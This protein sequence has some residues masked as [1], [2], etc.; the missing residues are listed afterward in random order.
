MKAWEW[1][2]H[3]AL[4]LLDDLPSLILSVV[5][6][7]PAIAAAI[8]VTFAKSRAWL[9]DIV[10][11]YRL[12]SLLVVVAVVF[13]AV[14]GW[15]LSKRLRKIAERVSA[16]ERNAITQIQQ[17]HAEFKHI[18]FKDEKLGIEWHVRQDPKDWVNDFKLYRHGRNF[19]DGI[20]GGPF[21]SE[22]K[23]RFLTYTCASSDDVCISGDCGFCGKTVFYWDEVSIHENAA[24]DAVEIANSASDAQQAVLSEIQRLHRAGADISKGHT[25]VRLNYW[26][27]VTRAKEYGAK[28]K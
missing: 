14:Y 10:E 23:E 17:A 28:A 25:L 19:I 3:R 2:K 8:G 12:A 6:G 11:V 22:C 24:G 21:H 13:F 15:I 18:I 5:L 16:L 1:V 26:A 27:W 20:L 7:L 9:L 4:K